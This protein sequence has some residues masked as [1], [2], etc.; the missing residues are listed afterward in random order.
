MTPIFIFSRV[1][2][3]SLLSAL[4]ASFYYE[5]A[6]INREPRQP[7][8]PFWPGEGERDGRARCCRPVAGCAVAGFF[9]LLLTPRRQQTILVISALV[10]HSAVTDRCFLL[11]IP[12]LLIPKR[13]CSQFLLPLFNLRTQAM[14]PRGIANVTAILFLTVTTPSYVATVFVED[15]VRDVG[16]EGRSNAA[17]SGGGGNPRTAFSS[18]LL[19]H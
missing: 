8:A 10:N 9:P 15:L 13:L 4:F 12:L 17:G 19:L 3:S 14:D 7:R 18:L 5:Q 6:R 1:V 11:L 2:L 16:R